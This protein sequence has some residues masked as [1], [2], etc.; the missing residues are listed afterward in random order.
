M[1]PLDR[2]RRPSHARCR[3]RH[4]VHGY[5][6]ALAQY[7]RLQLTTARCALEFYR[8]R[9]RAD[10]ETRVPPEVAMSWYIDTL[11]DRPEQASR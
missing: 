2:T 3:S 7:D 10:E 4:V 9:R 1:L 11:P 5:G 6:K 8:L